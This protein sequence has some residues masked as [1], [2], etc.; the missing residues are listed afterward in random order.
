MTF[1][2]K[3]EALDIKVRK[4]NGAGEVRINCPF[5][6]EMGESVDTRQRLGINFITGVANCFNCRWHSRTNTLAKILYKLGSADVQ[7]EQEK[8]ILVDD[9]D[10][11]VTLPEGFEYLN[12]KPKVWYHK[13]AFK[14]LKDRDIPNW[15]ITAKKLGVTIIG[16]FAYRIIF[17]V[18]HN[19]QLVGI[20]GRAW[21][22]TSKMKY[23]NSEG[24]KYL[25]NC[26]SGKKDIDTL[27]ISEGVFKALKIERVGMIASASMLGHD[28][29]EL[30]IKQLA[31][32]KSLKKVIVWPDPD[33]VGLRST[34][35]ACRKLEDAGYKAYTIHPPNKQADE[36]SD[37]RVKDLL[38]EPIH[39]SS[40]VEMRFRT[41][42]AFL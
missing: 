33:S 18:V 3:L 9:E 14:Y 23:L 27:V 7:I 10:I 21:T 8:S 37:R 38:E 40:L 25:W 19:K 29:T 15:Q 42:A 13:K 36:L 41:K 28:L 31:T 17:P 30:H 34:I 26:P 1:V 11:A 35:V 32:L 2:D 16:K 4:G 6:P 12:V 20:V 22:K 5:C 24:D 39:F